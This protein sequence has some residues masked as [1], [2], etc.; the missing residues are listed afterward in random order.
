MKVTISITG[1]HSEIDK[2]I[3]ENSLRSR[4]KLIEISKHSESHKAD[5]HESSKADVKVAKKV[6]PNKTKNKKIK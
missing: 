1:E 3:R 6:K 2:I 4:K 5:P